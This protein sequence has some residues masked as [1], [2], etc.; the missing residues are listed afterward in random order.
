[1]KEGI[2]ISLEYA[3]LSMLVRKP[4]SGYELGQLLD[5]FWQAKHSQ[6]Y[7]LLT[8]LE[9]EDLLGYEH[10][11]QSG[12]PDKK[13]YFLTD[14]GREHLQ[15]WI[16]KPPAVPIQRD[17]FLIKA[18]AIWLTD[19]ETAKQLF[20]D[21]IAAFEQKVKYR[22]GVLHE[23]EKEFGDKMEEITS[24]HFGRYILFQRRL[25]L[26]KEEIA[27]CHWVL[28]LLNKGKSPVS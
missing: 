26:D 22:E 20:T 13:I 18:Y 25:A 4:C 24:R 10:V 8:R 11:E 1:M 14:K 2:T 28:D 3:L 9:Q 27:W 16:S 7:P 17:E 15:K 21:R 19:I 6:I 5:V 12:K 23:M